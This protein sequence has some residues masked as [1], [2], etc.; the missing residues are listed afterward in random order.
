MPRL[1]HPETY[2]N[3]LFSFSSMSI[4]MD[5]LNIFIRIVTILSGGQ[6]RK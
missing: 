2:L 1:S 6:R 3:A 5:V 4:Y